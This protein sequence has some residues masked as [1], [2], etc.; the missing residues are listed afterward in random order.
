[1]STP[2]TDELRR[3]LGILTDRIA[4]D[5]ALELA[6]D[7]EAELDAAK[8]WITKDSER[9]G[10][11]RADLARVTAEREDANKIANT[12]AATCDEHAD[13][14]FTLRAELDRVTA[15]SEWRV[16]QLR[17]AVKE[18]DAIRA[19]VAEQDRVIDELQNAELKRTAERVQAEQR[20]AEL[21]DALQWAVVRIERLAPHRASEGGA[22]LYQFAK[23]K[24]LARAESAT[25]AKRPDEACPKCGKAKRLIGPRC[26]CEEEPAK[27]G[28]AT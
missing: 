17:K 21:V 12:W 18:A 16:E 23:A 10:V 3:Q 2:R 7:L 25:P 15:E 9:M 6:G 19:R 28:G 26:E 5:A 27:Q 8:A 20:N 4:L 22:E 13:E 14:I 1:M 24:A 11:L